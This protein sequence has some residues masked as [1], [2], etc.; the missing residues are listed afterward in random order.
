MFYGVAIWRVKPLTTITISLSDSSETCT[1]GS[2]FLF[3][4]YAKCCVLTNNLPKKNVKQIV[5]NHS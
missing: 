1:V 3:I 5:A 2:A 4:N